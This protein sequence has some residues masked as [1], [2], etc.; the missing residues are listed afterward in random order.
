M[1]ILMCRYL[2]KNKNTTL[3]TMFLKIFLTVKTVAVLAD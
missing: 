2:N 1:L 3:N